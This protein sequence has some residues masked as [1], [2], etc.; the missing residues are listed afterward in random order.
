MAPFGCPLVLIHGLLPTVPLFLS[1]CW[2]GLI[3]L[4]TPIFVGATSHPVGPVQA[5]HSA[6]RDPS[7][8]HIRAYEHHQLAQTVTKMRRQTKSNYVWCLPF[9]VKIETAREG[10]GS[11][12]E[13]GHWIKFLI[14]TRA[15]HEMRVIWDGDVSIGL[16][17]KVQGSEMRFPLA[18]ANSERCIV[19]IYV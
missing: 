19:Q 17:Q 7:P 15:V 9:S 16:Y 6:P 4:A 1:C 14:A 13:L 5:G 11:Y 3:A 8:S 12:P 10:A 18:I 2:P